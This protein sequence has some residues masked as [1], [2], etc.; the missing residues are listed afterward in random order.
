M[1]IN[2][3]QI[4]SGETGASIS[5]HQG[6]KLK[7]GNLRGRES[8]RV[9]SIDYEPGIGFNDDIGLSSSAVCASLCTHIKPFGRQPIQRR[10]AF[11]LRV[12]RIDIPTGTR[13]SPVDCPIHQPSLSN[14]LRRVVVPLW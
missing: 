4:I 3:R 10:Q 7:G 13:P 12:L 5:A 1:R 14:H 6:E 11:V 8:N 2:N 9:P